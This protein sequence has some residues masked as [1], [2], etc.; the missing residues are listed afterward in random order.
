MSFE[1]VLVWLEQYPYLY[2]IVMV[3][4]VLVLSLIAYLITKHYV[5]K[6]VT[7]LIRRSKIKYDDMLVQE[8]LLRRLSYLAPLIVIHSFASQFPFADIIHKITTALFAWFV[9]LAVG[10]FL[11][12]FQ[13]VYQTFEIAKGRSIKSYVQI[14]KLILYIM[15]AIIIVGAL[16]GRSPMV[17]LSGFG[18]MTAVILLIF[19]DTI[20]SFVASLQISSNDLVSGRRLDRIAKI[21]CRR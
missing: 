8:A 14:I 18:A 3:L 12:G 4:G 6:T 2:Q 5:C 1:A 11:T 19:R 7:A 10:A 13:E 17:L 9:V 21:R 16:L 15:G 20:L